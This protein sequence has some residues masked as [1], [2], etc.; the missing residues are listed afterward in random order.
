MDDHDI[1]TLIAD[2]LNAAVAALD[3]E[4]ADATENA[5]ALDRIR[6]FAEAQ[7]L[8]RD[9]GLVLHLKDGSQFYVTIVQGR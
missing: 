1:E 5:E 8:T 4:D 6:T 9:A 3:D 7:V 2:T